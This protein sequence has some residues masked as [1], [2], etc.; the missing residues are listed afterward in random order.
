MRAITL[1]PKGS[2]LRWDGKNTPEDDGSTESKIARATL[3]VQ[4]NPHSAKV[5]A[6]WSDLTFAIPAMEDAIE[7]IYGG[8]VSTILENDER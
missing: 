1:G 5:Q 8:P 6:D 7:E 3:E 4:P 2:V